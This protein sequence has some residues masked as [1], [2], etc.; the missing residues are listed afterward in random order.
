MLKLKFSS[1]D[2]I[3]NKK[4]EDN[5]EGTQAEQND[6]VLEDFSSHGGYN[7]ARLAQIAVDL[8]QT[9]ARAFHLL[10]L[11]EQIAEYVLSGLFGLE[12]DPVAVL[13]ILVHSAHRFAILRLQIVQLV[14]LL[15]LV[16]MQFDSR[17]I[18]TRR[19][20]IFH[21]TVEF[22]FEFVQFGLFLVNIFQFIIL[23]GSYI[24]L[25]KQYLVAVDDSQIFLL[26]FGRSLLRRVYISN[27]E[28]HLLYDL[29]SFLEQLFNG[30]YGFGRFLFWTGNGSRD[31][32]RYVRA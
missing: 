10:A 32:A 3:D 5:Q 17:S 19:F 14:V 15:A 21:L 27:L 2:E 4:D 20:L 6:L 8:A 12:N 28:L 13:Q 22:Y 25:F 1:N 18:A 30:P 9:V 7:A 24:D 29:L 23:I 26:L 31:L 16:Q 11:T